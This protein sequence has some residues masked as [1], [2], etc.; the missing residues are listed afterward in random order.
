MDNDVNINRILT[1]EETTEKDY[2]GVDEIL[3]TVDGRSKE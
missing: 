2:N 3:Q 1:I